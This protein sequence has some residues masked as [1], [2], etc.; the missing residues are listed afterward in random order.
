MNWILFYADGSTF[1]N[2]D[3]EA[4]ESPPSGMVAFAQNHPDVGHEVRDGHTFIFKDDRWW[5]CDMQGVQDQLI[6]FAHEIQA[7]RLGRWAT[8]AEYTNIMKRARESNLEPKSAYNFNERA[9]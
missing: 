6:H 1:S 4:H 2:L 7:Y 8:D 3:G 9:I 5:S